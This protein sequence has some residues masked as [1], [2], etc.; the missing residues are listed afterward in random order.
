[1]SDTSPVITLARTESSLVEDWGVIDYE[2]ALE[3]QKH[4]VA[5]RKAGEREDTLAL[6]EHPA[7]FTI[8]AR[9]GAERHVLWDQTR[10]AQEAVDLVK[11]NR[12]GDVTYHGPGQIVGYVIADVQQSRDLHRVLRG[13]EDYVIRSI[14]HY[15][16]AGTRRPGKTGIWLGERKIAAI[17]LAS[18]KW[19][20]YHGF[21]LNL[22][23]NLHHF[24]GI[25]PCGIT[26]GTVTSMAVEMDGESPDLVRV[27][28][29]LSEGFESLL[30]EIR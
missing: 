14:A 21:S 11:S 7:V 22:D 9:T 8:G 28:Q 16:L 30:S 18:S 26:D 15:G 1:M 17:G 4:Y 5:Q 20:T 3:R 10:R 6:L 29:I 13:V 2:E 24:E 23:P 25:V 27:K 12:G 19:I